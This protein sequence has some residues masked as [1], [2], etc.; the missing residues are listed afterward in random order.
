MRE[1]GHSGAEASV[2]VSSEIRECHILPGLG[3]EESFASCQ[4]IQ[5]FPTEASSL[6]QQEEDNLVLVLPREPVSV[7]N[8]FAVFLTHLRMW[9]TI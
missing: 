1:T 3:S 6:R 5:F 4:L 2:Q 7:D 8:F 9:I